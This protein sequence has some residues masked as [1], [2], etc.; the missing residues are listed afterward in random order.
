MQPINKSIHIQAKPQA[1]WAVLIDNEINRIWL[2]EFS[3][4]T[5]AHT[6]W[7]EGSRVSFTDH[8]GSGITGIIR[9]SKPAR[10]LV[11]EY[12]GMLEQGREDFESDMAQAMKGTREEYYLT[13]TDGGTRLD[14]HLSAM[15]EEV[16]E[17]MLAAWDRALA[18]WK[19]LAEAR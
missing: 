2:S 12:D 8:S 6:D 17:M 4:D 16:M 19:A 14:I 15:P 10:E 3:E 7:A 9:S 5:Q 11:M 18:Q 13:E 1:V